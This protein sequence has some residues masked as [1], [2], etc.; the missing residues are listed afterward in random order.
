MFLQIARRLAERLMPQLGLVPSFSQAQAVTATQ[1]QPFQAFK[2]S[3][4]T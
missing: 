4:G 2:V 3:A 1:G